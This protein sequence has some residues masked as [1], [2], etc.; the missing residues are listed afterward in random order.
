MT[1]KRPLAWAVRKSVLVFQKEFVSHTFLFSFLPLFSHLPYSSLIRKG[2][3]LGDWESRLS[4]LTPP[5]T[6]CVILSKFLTSPS[7]SF[8]ICKM[9]SD[10][11]TCL[12]GFLQ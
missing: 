3:T 11:R 7:L 6:S 4:I 8:L 10:I 12:I 1:E 2:S 9:W 5:L